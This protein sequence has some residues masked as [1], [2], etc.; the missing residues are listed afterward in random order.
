MARKKKKSVPSKGDRKLFLSKEAEDELV[1]PCP[2]LQVH[3]LLCMPV[4]TVQ[5]LFL[6][7]RWRLRR[8]SLHLMRT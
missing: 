8:F 4:F 7:C 3:V 5:L 1:R 2:T 6:V